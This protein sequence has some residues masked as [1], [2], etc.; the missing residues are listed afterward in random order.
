MSIPFGLFLI[1]KEA[2]HIAFIFTTTVAIN[3][4]FNIVN[5]F[6]LVIPTPFYKKPFEF[7]IGF[8]KSFIV[9]IGCYVLTIISI[10]VNNFNLGV[11]S[12]LVTFLT[13]MSF[14]SKPE[15][16]SYVWNYSK[17]P[18]AFLIT[19]IKTA[20]TFSF[21]IT[22]PIALL[23]LFFNIDMAFYIILF[24]FVGMLYI[25]NNILSKYAYYPSEININQA[26]I[27]GASIMFPPLM[28]LTIPL[29]Y[30]RAKQQL[31]TI[32]K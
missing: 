20:L 17:H 16:L 8:R 6:S 19:K 30:S 7:T 32:L 12:M 1:Y 5:N 2:Y 22:I 4:Q 3:S 11:F 28:L 29:F 10:K 13:C 24:Q 15:P 14:Y 21:L 9:F 27:V 18:I 31:N 23:L 25:V 26:F